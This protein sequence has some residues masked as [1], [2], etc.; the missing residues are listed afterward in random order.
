MKTWGKWL[1]WLGLAIAIVCVAVGTTLAVT[2][3]SKLTDVADDSFRVNGPT[4]HLAD[5]GE[6]LVLY[7]D[8]STTVPSCQIQGPAQPTR[9][10]VVDGDL[11]FDSETTTPFLAWQFTESGAYTITCDQSGVVAGP[12][13]PVGGIISGAGGVL[14]AVFGGGLGAVMLV[15]GVILWIVGANRTKTPP[16]P[17]A[18]QQPYPPQP[19]S[20]Y[21]PH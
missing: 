7:Y 19:G 10:S 21:P 3:F 14:L 5:A 13:L 12:Q 11:S 9:G 8:D 2:G 4:P 18:W 20:P 1:T 17:G 6:T 16:P 15:V